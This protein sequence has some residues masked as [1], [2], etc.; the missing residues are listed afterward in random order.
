MSTEDFIFLTSVL[1]RKGDIV[2]SCNVVF[3]M[4]GNLIIRRQ[5]WLCD[6]GVKCRIFKH[7][8]AT[9]LHDN[10]LIETA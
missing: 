1:F 10:D 9:F 8:K 6:N 2:F 5:L 7:I 4:H 3:L